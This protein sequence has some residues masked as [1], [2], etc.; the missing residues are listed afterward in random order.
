MNEMSIFG[1]V[2]KRWEVWGYGLRL[3]ITMLMFHLIYVKFRAP[4][5]FNGKKLSIHNESRAPVN[6]LSF[7]RSRSF[8]I[9]I[10]VDF[11]VAS[12]LADLCQELLEEGFIGH[13]SHDEPQRNKT[14][15][16]E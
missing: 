6:S 12:H 1:W 10:P 4:H 14:F 15:K 8:P 11:I 16:C 7:L 13:I 2:R 9:V 5:P 3:V